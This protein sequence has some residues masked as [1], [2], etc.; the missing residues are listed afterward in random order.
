MYMCVC[1]G[2]IG[3]RLQL[4]LCSAIPALTLS[5]LWAV[6]A[7]TGNRQTYIHIQCMYTCMCVLC[8]H[9]SMHNIDKKL[10]NHN[11]C[12]NNYDFTITV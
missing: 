12:I 6:E 10:Q 2:T 5:L 8:P 4:T 9:D 11:F 3:D 1:V 7:S